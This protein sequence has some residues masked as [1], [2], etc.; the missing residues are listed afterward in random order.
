MSPLTESW[1][2]ARVKEGREYRR[3]MVAEE[4]S[5]VATTKKRRVSDP[6]LMRAAE[7]EKTWMATISDAVHQGSVTTASA[8]SRRIG[9]LI[10]GRD[11]FEYAG[12]WLEEYKTNETN[13]Q[14]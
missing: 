10:P 8:M 11:P 12:D 2:E 4:R 6:S 14:Q 7:E 13:D 1:S 5:R 3:K 9:H